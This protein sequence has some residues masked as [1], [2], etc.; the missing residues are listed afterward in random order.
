MSID[1][2]LDS[3]GSFQ[4]VHCKIKDKIAQNLNTIS[5]ILRMPIGIVHSLNIR[6][7][8]E[9][10][11]MKRRATSLP[12]SCPLN[13]VQCSQPQV[14]ELVCKLESNARGERRMLFYVLLL[15]D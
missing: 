8:V 4:F 2:L 12:S 10:D 7:N 1:A 9:V 13:P 5:L 6:G 15:T 14:L 11:I 3:N